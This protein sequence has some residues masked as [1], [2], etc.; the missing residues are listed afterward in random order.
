M[1]FIDAQRIVDG[2]VGSVVAVRFYDDKRRR[3]TMY[4]QTNS[5]PDSDRLVELINCASGAQTKS[6][7]DVGA[8]KTIVS[9]LKSDKTCVAC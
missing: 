5:E 4:V 3:C 1:N 8:L 7:L 2:D 9:K 6:P